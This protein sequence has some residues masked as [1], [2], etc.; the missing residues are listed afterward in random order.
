ME[1][2][3]SIHDRPDTCGIAQQYSSATFVSICFLA[4]KEEFGALFKKII[5]SIFSISVEDL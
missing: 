1:T 4:Y 3:R 5:I 2:D